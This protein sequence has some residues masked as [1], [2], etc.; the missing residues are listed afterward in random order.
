MQKEKVEG[1]LNWPAPRNIKEVQ[2]FLDLANYYKRFIKDFARIAAPLHVLVRKEQKQKW[3]KEQEKVFKRL[4]AIFTTEPIL[5]ILDINREMRVEVNASDYATVGVL[6]TKYEDGKQRLVIFISKLL[7]VTE[8]NYK[9]YDKKILA[10]IRCL[11]A[12]RYYLEGAKLKFKIW[13]D[14]KNLQYFIMS[15]KLN[16][17]QAKWALY[18]LQFNFV[19][20]YIPERSMGKVDRLSRRLDW[21]KGV[22]KDNKDQK[23]IKPEQIKEAETIIEGENLKNRIKKAQEGDKKVVKVVEELKRAGI[24]MLKNKEWK[25]EYRIIMKKEKIYIPEKKLRK[26]MI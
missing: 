17:R 9:I 10:I 12:Q 14:R 15:Q 23:L 4:K 8:Q 19:L 11:E 20:K 18:L 1:V 7:N 6:L 13:T 5:A 22:E 26:E 16:Y 25:I 3:K 24:K 2:K 21:Q